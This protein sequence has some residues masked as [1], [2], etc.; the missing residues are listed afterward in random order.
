MAEARAVAGGAD[1]YS[2]ERRTALVLTGV[3]ASGAYHAG[4]L[5][6]FHDAGVKIDLVAAHGVGA[7]AALFA[8]L[9]GGAHVWAPDGFWRPSGAAGF[10]RWRPAL[11]FIGWAA[12]VLAVLTLAPLAGVLAGAIAYPI[13][14][15]LRLLGLGGGETLEGAFSAALAA[16]FARD[17]LPSIIPRLIAA[18]LLLMIGAIA[19]AG[20]WT[21]LRA[22]RRSAGASWR[23]VLFAPVDSSAVVE[24]ARRALWRLLHGAPPGRRRDDAALSRRCVEV[25][26]QNLGQPGFREIVLVTHDLDARRDLAF[27]ALAEPHRRRFFAD[28]ADAAEGARA[29]EAVDLLGGGQTHV[30]D[31]L[32]GALTLP[33]ASAPWPI[34]FG[35]D[36]YWRGET[37][38][39]CDR[40]DAIGRLLE[41]TRAAGCEQVIIASATPAPAGPHHLT[42]PAAD[43]RARVGEFLSGLDSTSL[44]DAAVAW[45]SAFRGFFVIRPQHNPIGPL[46]VA[47]CF[48]P[49]SEREASLP[50]LIDRGYED[51][52][53]QFIEPVLG[54]SG[55][56]LGRR[57]L[58]GRARS[59]GR[60]GGAH[61]AAAHE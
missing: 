13:A 54:A 8:S 21:R 56:G 15:V 12:A 31:A 48:D 47:G 49:Q 43:G 2:P 5:H 44:R 53:R 11:R 4:V 45:R 10:Y 24:A 50:E 29:A 28:H 9:D 7:V 20:V 41:E 60:T 42:P 17:A 27:A 58:R 61:G 3:G 51:A 1:S 36:S 34:A 35:A 57:P 46:D 39:L 40:P 16:A 25:L 55:E 23:E 18:A 59:E 32:A 26:S 19:I 30:V 38:R 33:G 52:S 22:R 6:A 37:H 14:Y